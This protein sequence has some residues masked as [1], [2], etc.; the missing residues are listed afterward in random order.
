MAAVITSEVATPAPGAAGLGSGRALRRSGERTR[1]QASTA[2]TATPA[3]AA[4]AFPSTGAALGSRAAGASRAA[5]TITSSF[6]T[7]RAARNG[8]TPAATQMSQ[9]TTGCP[10]RRARASASTDAISAGSI[11]VAATSASAQPGSTCLPTFTYAREPAA[12]G[13]PAVSS[14]ETILRSDRPISP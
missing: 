4:A 1:I 12:G 9:R 10:R 2:T 11:S 6:P 13:M 5:P 3:T 14:A 8:T 7:P